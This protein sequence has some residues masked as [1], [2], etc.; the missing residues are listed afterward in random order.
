MGLMAGGGGDKG[1]GS[2]KKAADDVDAHYIGLSVLEDKQSRLVFFQS[3]ADAE[4]KITVNKSLLKRC[5]AA[6]LNACACLLSLPCAR[7][8]CF[9]NGP[10]GWFAG[11]RTC[12]F[13][14]S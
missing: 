1:E 13:T 7:I 3:V 6:L 4:D 10:I 8:P 11:I 5:A 14:P 12:R 9:V 2:K